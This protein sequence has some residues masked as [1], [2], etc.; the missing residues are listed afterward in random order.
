MLTRGH[1][2]G[3]LV[4]DF[5]SVA[6]Q[7]RQRGKIHLFDIH[8]YVEDFVCEVLNRIYGL[9]LVNL[10]KDSLNHPGLDLGDKAKRIAFQVTADRSTNKM[11]E[12]LKKVTAADKA[13]YD[14]IRVFVIGEKQGS[15]TLDGEPFAGFGFSKDNIL[16]FDDLCAA[17]MPLGLPALMSLARY[18]RD[19]LRRV[20]VE[21]EIPDENGITQ[22]SIDAYVEALPKPTLSDAA[23][24]NA[25]YVQARLDFDQK[26]AADSIKA[27]SEMLSPLPRQTREVF[28]LMLQRRRPDTAYSEHFFIH[29][30]T[31]RRIYPREDLPEDLQLLDHAGLID[32]TDWGDGKAPYWRLMIPG[33]GTNFHM[34]FVDYAEAKGINLNK[35]L[36]ALDF[37]DF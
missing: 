35:P 7:A 28:R 23:K 21:L 27:L 15:Y 31:L 16:D 13:A 25:Y 26:D 33:W 36:V 19:E 8:T 20:I 10:N 24:M 18:V 22:S 2:I 12:T 4:D 14:T 9:E 1:L 37:S 30:A 32:Y 3:Q 11:K 34:I 29:D 5:A 17:L 6:A